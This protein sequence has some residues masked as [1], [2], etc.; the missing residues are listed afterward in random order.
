MRERLERGLLIAILSLFVALS[1]T[2]SVVVPPFEA[3]DE[4]WHY[5]MVKYIAG[6]GRLPVQDPA[7]VGPWRQ[8]GSQAP[9]YYAIGA[10]ATAWIDTSDMA[11]VRH[12]NPHVD[13]GVATP[14]GNVNLVVHNPTREAFPWQGTV[15]AVH[16]V[17]LLSVGMSATAVYLTWRIAREVLPDQPALALGMTAVHAFTPMYVFISGAVNNDNLVVPLSSLA[18]L[19][20]LRLLRRRDLSR[21]QRV[22]RYL[23]L[24][25]VLGL[26]ALTKSSSL[27]LT[28]L[29]ALVVVVRA[30]RRRSWWEFLV[31][32]FGTL[33]P[34]LAV[35]GWWFL[36]NLRLYG[37]P[38]GL[39]VFVEILGRRDVPA[40]LAQLWRERFSFAAGYW[41]N[42]GGLNVPMPAWVYQLLN[43]L[44]LVA[45]LGLL[46]V[47]A[48][49]LVV[50]YR[51][52]VPAERW[53]LGL[54]RGPLALCL[55]WGLGVV[56]PWV[57]WASVTWSSQ[58][59]LIFAALPVWALLLTLGWVGWLP[60]GWRRWMLALLV[61]F[62]LGLSAA[63]PFA[64]IRPAY[65][66]PPQLS[67]AQV[68]ARAEPLAASFGGTMRLLGYRIEADEVR[69]GD[70]L[71][72]TL[73][74]EALA[75]A[76]R[77]YTVFVHLVGTGDLLIAQ[78]DTFPGLGLL[79]TTWLEPGYRWADRY[80]LRVPETAYAPDEARVAVGLYDAGTGARLEA[81]GPAG[82]RLGDHVRFGDVTVR[83][84]AGEV[85]NPIA[86]NF[87]DRMRLVG[88]ALDRRVVSPQETL[89]LTLYWEGVRPMDAD[90]TISAQLVDPD[91]RKA[92]QQDSW[93]QEGA[94]PT[95]GWA[96]GQVVADRRALPIY[97]DAPPGVYDVR[98]AVYLHDGQELVHLPVLSASGEMAFD[99]VVLTRVRVAP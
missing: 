40:D 25:V 18:L 16:L 38:T 84:R 78:R 77:E 37:D 17:R 19:M 9:L 60:R 73:Y 41:G 23:S 62:L 74:W 91:Q 21:R 5:P 52:R 42:F 6:H 94:A 97:P 76:E 13:N 27:A 57:Q 80:V 2:Y 96:A 50:H 30:A 99:Y 85:P 43:A 3:S 53:R 28:I 44:T 32:G 67:E 81:V 71:A 4:L 68:A 56:L 51:G 54:R 7:A 89:H 1:V 34:L 98:V 63:A 72:V 88:Y 92:A 90:Y 8:E 66:L 79:S 33:L 87:G 86:I 26:T 75:P 49:G 83:P 35:A 12:L 58:G 36:R 82:E 15:L 70:R 69:P 93:P 59:R 11:Q 20:L 24:G 55:L 64:W 95:T 46:V 39:N 22:A 45:G 65:A 61:A 31:G 29:T 48:R 14:D 10:L 47:A